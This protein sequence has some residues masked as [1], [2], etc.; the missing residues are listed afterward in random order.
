MKALIDYRY[1]YINSLYP[2]SYILYSEPHT[3]LDTAFSSSL[4]LK[5]KHISLAYSLRQVNV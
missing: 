3:I 5:H 4:I 1:S 2:Y